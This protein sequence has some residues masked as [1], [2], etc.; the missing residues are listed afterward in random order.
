MERGYELE[1]AVRLFS[2][3]GDALVQAVLRTHPLV[4]AATALVLSTTIF[5]V[6]GA[7]ST[8]PVLCHPRLSYWLLFV[9][10]ITQ[11]PVLGALHEMVGAVSENDA[12]AAAVTQAVVGQ[13]FAQYTAS[14]L[15]V[16]IMSQWMLLSLPLSVFFLVEGHRCRFRFT[17]CVSVLSLLSSKTAAVSL[18][19]V[20]MINC[21][22][23]LSSTQWPL[24]V[25]WV[26]SAGVAIAAAVAGFVSSM[27]MHDGLLHVASMAAA[28]LCLL[29]PELSKSL[30]TVAGSFRRNDQASG[31]AFA[32]DEDLNR[33][34][35]N[36]LLRISLAALY[37]FLAGV[38][39]VGHWVA[40]VVLIRSP[41]IGTLEALPLLGKLAL[42]DCCAFVGLIALLLRISEREALDT[43]GIPKAAQ[44]TGAAHL[45]A[46]I[47]AAAV[48]GP[49]AGFTM[50]L[51]CR[52]VHVLLPAPT[53]GFSEGFSE[54]S[55]GTPDVFDVFPLQG[56]RPFRRRRS[57]GDEAQAAQ[58][59]PMD[60]TQHLHDSV[61]DTLTP[62]QGQLFPPPR[63]RK[64]SSEA[65]G[66]DSSRREELALGDN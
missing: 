5:A 35:Q 46:G 44:C 32:P 24:G 66:L 25:Q 56:H 43:C 64:S 27:H 50:L 13:V 18:L 52:E 59:R 33:S 51:A 2:Q 39:L 21:P 58:F 14:P 34:R 26:A 9:A 16:L 4:A 23:V 11:A 31:D 17:M 28:W 53:R 60:P 30:F 20:G 42:A 10:A 38:A 3:Y 6:A 48:V 57:S 63:R 12:S 47:A 19:A 40:I 7:F 36:F 15:T 54:S 8:S 61:P 1:D 49:A 29:L 65:S 45:I 55:P 22:Q 62:P 37:T 41:S